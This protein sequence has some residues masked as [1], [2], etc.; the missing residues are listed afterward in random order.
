MSALT[1][2]APPAPAVTRTST[3][4]RPGT[5]PTSRPGASPTS[6]PV[7]RATAVA[8]ASDEDLLVAA[9]DGDQRAF[10]ALYDRTSSAVL[11]VCI[12]VVRDRTM[13]EEV[14]QEVMVEAWRK[15]ARFDPERGSAMAWITTLAHRRAV[16]R[17]RSEQAHRDRHERVATTDHEPAFDVVADEVATRAEHRLVREALAT[18]TERQREA[19]E[20]AYFGGRTY[21]DVAEVL[22]IPE[23]TAKSRLRDGLERLRRTLEASALEGAL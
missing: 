5:S 4:S 18:L 8:S 10:A 11:G 9:A 14:L 15:A 1:I 7:A 2:A 6:R 3:T 19:V 16:D 23:G 20:L 22:Q 12:R 17:V 21:R 13:A